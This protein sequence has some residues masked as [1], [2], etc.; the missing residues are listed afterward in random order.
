MKVGRKDIEHLAELA[1]IRLSEDE[2]CGLLADLES[3]IDYVGKLAE[4]DT[5]GVEAMAGGTDLTNRFREDEER[6]DSFENKADL[7][8]AAPAS[9][10]SDGGEGIYFK[11]PRILE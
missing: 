8:E 11:V 7:L 10:K 5:E 3:I 2:E 4:V 9:E 1:R 6:I